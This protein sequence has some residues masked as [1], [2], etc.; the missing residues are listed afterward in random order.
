ML[1]SSWEVKVAEKLDQ[2]KIKWIRPKPLKWV[3]NN[4]TRYYFPDFYLPDYNL[5]LDPK[6]PYCMDKDIKKMKYFE[7]KINIVYGDIYKVLEI[8]NN[9]NNFPR[10]GELVNPPDC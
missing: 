8:I 6:N 2:L 7:D 4:K 3:D 9:L 10:V 1:E 5:Y